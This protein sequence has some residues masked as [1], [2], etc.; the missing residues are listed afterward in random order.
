[1]GLP[2]ADLNLGQHFLKKLIKKNNNN[3]CF[4]F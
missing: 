1:M 2:R 3:F 4:E